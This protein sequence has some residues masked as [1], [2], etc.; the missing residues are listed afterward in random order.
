MPDQE[1]IETIRQLRR[2]YPGIRIVAMSGALDDVYLKTAE[3]LGAHV[4]LRKPIDS[5]DLLRIIRELLT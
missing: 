5:Q 2:D 3:F 1:G 4:A